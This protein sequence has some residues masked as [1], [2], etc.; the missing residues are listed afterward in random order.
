MNRILIG[1]VGCG[2]TVC[3]AYAMYLTVKNGHQ[4]ALMVPTE[5]LARLGP[6]LTATV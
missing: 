4:A 3:A 5:I 2:K 1:D 6:R